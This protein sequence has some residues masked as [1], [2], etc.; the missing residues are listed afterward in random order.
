MDQGLEEQMYASGVV[1]TPLAHY[2]LVRELFAQKDFS[3]EKVLA[4]PFARKFPPTATLA[5]WFAHVTGKISPPILPKLYSPG[6]AGV[7]EYCQLA[8]LWEAF[9]KAA[10]RTDFCEEARKLAGWLAPLVVEGLSA[11]W[12]QD[13]GSPDQDVS[14]ALFLRAIGQDVAIPPTSKFFAFLEQL[15]LRIDPLLAT[16]DYQLFRGRGWAAAFTWVGRGSGAG[17]CRM[18]GVKIPAFGPQAAPFSDLSRFG[19]EGAGERWFFSTGCKEAWFQVEPSQVDQG[20]SFSL[21]SMGLTPEKPLAWVFYVCADT[22]NIQ[23][24][25]FKPKSLHRFLGEGQKVQFTGGATNVVLESSHPLKMELIP[26]AG[27]TSFW[28]ASFLLAFW[29]SPHLGKTSFAITAKGE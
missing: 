10:G 20:F 23:G 3:L 28:G 9:G 18:G 15:N 12:T 4:H 24:K 21:Q 27:E 8:L 11:L 17:A 25:S 2:A 7:A 6:T 29:L 5:G 14:C 22:C 19:I 13:R 26:L 16:G 1:D